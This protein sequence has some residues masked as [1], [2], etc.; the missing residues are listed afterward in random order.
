M[1]FRGNLAQHGIFRKKD[2][3][4]EIPN[5]AV[6]GSRH[7]ISHLA[8]NPEWAV[9][10]EDFIGP[11]GGTLPQPWATQD[12]S[13]SGTPVKDYVEGAAN[14]VYNLAFATTTEAETL[15]MYWGDNLL[16]NAWN[17]FLF[18]TKITL[19]PDVTGEGGALGANDKFVFGIGSARNATLDS[20]TLNAWFRFEGANNNILFEAD[21]GTTD[22]DDNDSGVDWADGAALD[23]AIDGRVLSDVKFY[24]NGALVNPNNTVSVAGFSAGAFVQPF[25]EMQKASAANMDHSLVI[26]YIG[27]ATKRNA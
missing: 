7:L 15:S 1:S 4:I 27:I 10:F 16:L 8:S 14:G 17:G 20:M 13:L 3:R 24:V 21:D 2:D 19:A 12:T 26:D 5:L 11:A 23:L 6:P 9:V 22:D 18:C 25:I